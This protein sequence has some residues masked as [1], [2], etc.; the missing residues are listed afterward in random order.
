MRATFCDI[1]RKQMTLADNESYIVEI[2]PRRCGEYIDKLDV[3]VECQEDF[4]R[5]VR[6]RRKHENEEA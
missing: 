3:C 5:F 6:E 4:K 2:Y 1:C